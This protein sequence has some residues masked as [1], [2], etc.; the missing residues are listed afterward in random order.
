MAQL[1]IHGAVNG[2]RKS[3]LWDLDALQAPVF[4]MTAITAE[5]QQTSSVIN[6]FGA[7]TPRS[8]ADF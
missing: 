1:C 3:L 8:G 2:P 4:G 7:A 6:G 5:Q